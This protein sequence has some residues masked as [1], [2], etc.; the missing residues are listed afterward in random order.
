[1]GTI[2]AVAVRVMLL[3]LLLLVLLLVLLVPRVVDFAQ[4]SRP[5]G[6]IP[7]KWADVFSSS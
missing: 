1:M 5:L 3:L 6:D 4:V 7:S 2:S